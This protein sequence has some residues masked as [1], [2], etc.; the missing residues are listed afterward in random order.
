MKRAAL[1]AILL[2]LVSLSLSGQIKSTPS[3]SE[4]NPARLRLS[5]PPSGCPLSLHALQG[6]G[7]GLVA[8][9]RRAPGDHHEKADG[10]LGFVPPVPAQH[11]HLVATVSSFPG[12]KPVW[13]HFKVY[14]RSGSKHAEQVRTGSAM[15]PFD[16]EKT[17]TLDERFSPEDNDEVAADLTLPGFTS[18]KSIQVESITYQD[19][20]T[21]VVGAGQSCQIAP[22]P[23]MLVAD[24]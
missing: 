2:V 14:G 18:V 20:S 7:R 11:I 15:K 1:I 3:V 23:L 22:D 17:L 12:G 8:V 16:Y 4:Q 10:P 6:S 24:H 13:G 21:W 5:G 9:V 19:G